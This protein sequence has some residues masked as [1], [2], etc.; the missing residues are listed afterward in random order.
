MSDDDRYLRERREQA[1]W[2][3][4]GVFTAERGL[5]AL[6]RKHR[7]LALEYDRLDYE[8]WP[9]VGEYEVIGW[10]CDSDRARLGVLPR[11]V[12]HRTARA[13]ALAAWQRVRAR[14][15]D[16]SRATRFQRKSDC[17]FGC[18]SIEYVGP[19]PGHG[20][21]PECSGHNC[22]RVG[23]TPD[24][25]PRYRIRWYGDP[26]LTHGYRVRPP[27]GGDLGFA[28]EAEAEAAVERYW[29]RCAATSSPDRGCAPLDTVRAGRRPDIYC[30]WRLDDE[31]WSYFDSDAAN[32]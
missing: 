19:T 7:Y 5:G 31:D 24:D 3:A 28:T 6:S 10:H 11:N 27:T 32:P 15:R 12:R 4:L 23:C 16:D 29:A 1:W 30:A 2:G 20:H 18:I 8:G 13:A 17:E 25:G 14:H 26:G 9:L 22:E 21:L